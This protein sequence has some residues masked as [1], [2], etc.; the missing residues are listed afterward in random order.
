[1][2]IRNDRLR[3]K[4]R[5]LHRMR[6]RIN[7]SSSVFCCCCCVVFGMFSCLAVCSVWN[8]HHSVKHFSSIWIRL[9]RQRWTRTQKTAWRNSFDSLALCVTSAR[10]VCAD[11]RFGRSGPKRARAR[12]SKRARL[13]AYSLSLIRFL[14]N[15]HTFAYGYYMRMCSI[16]WEFMRG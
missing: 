6:D 8:A 1:M 7:C 10:V 16:C 2:L 9:S 15:T 13:F 12:E 3:T 5:L 14:S 4:T 11:G